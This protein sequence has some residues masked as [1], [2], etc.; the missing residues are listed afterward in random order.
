MR[1]A[2][3]TKLGIREVGFGIVLKR[4]LNNPSLAYF[5][6]PVN[7]D[8]DLRRNSSCEVFILDDDFCDDDQ[9]VSFIAKIRSQNPQAKIIIYGVD[10]RTEQIASQ[11]GVLCHIDYSGSEHLVEL[12]TT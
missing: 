11:N 7:F 5:R 10:R 9:M 2:I 4:H 3:I 8:E 1:I 12:I 6:D